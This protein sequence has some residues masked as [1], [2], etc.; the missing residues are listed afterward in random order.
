MKNEDLWMSLRFVLS[1]MDRSTQSLDS[2]ALEGRLSTG[3][4]PLSAYAFFTQ[5]LKN[6]ALLEL[7][8]IC[9]VVL[10]VACFALWVK[11]LK[12]DCLLDYS[13]FQKF[14]PFEAY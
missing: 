14:V 13:D 10:T 1:R 3:R 2:E 11:G 8:I 12:Q 4:I 9:W 5:Y 7:K 6:V